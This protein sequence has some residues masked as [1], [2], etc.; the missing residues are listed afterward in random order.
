MSNAETV[1][2]ALGEVFANEETEVDD[3]L[4]ERMIAAISTIAAADFV[5]RMYGPDDTFVGTY[6]GA[7]GVRAGWADWLESF[8]R[9]RF[10]FESIEEVGENVLTM[11]TQIGTTRTGGVEIEQPSA[12]VWKFHDGKLRETEFHLDRDKARSSAE[13]A[14]G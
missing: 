10:Q 12:A 4:I 8:D 6:E 2:Q 13:T 14:F 11:A 7:A 9:V 3:A 5:M 1:I